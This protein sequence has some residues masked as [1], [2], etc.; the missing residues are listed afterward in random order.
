[1][2]LHLQLRRSCARCAGLILLRMSHCPN[3]HDRFIPFP[4]LTG[5]RRPLEKDPSYVSLIPTSRSNP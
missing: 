2:T 3:D 1:M 5:A 4:P